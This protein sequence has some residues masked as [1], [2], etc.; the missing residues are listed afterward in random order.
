MIVLRSSIAANQLS[1]QQAKKTT[2][3]RKTGTREAAENVWI[4]AST[5]IATSSL[6][7]VN[8]GTSSLAGAQKLHLY[9]MDSPIF[10]GEMKDYPSFREDWKNIL[11]REL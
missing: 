9:K 5:P 1:C 4:T 7:Q 2:E 11:E 8:C 3:A 10:S 6:P